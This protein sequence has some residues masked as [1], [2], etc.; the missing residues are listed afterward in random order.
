MLSELLILLLFAFFSLLGG[1]A[2]YVVLGVLYRRREQQ[3]R[4]IERRLTRDVHEPLFTRYATKPEENP[5]AQ[6]PRNN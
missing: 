1:V 4:L 2:V 6:K 5:S 3:N